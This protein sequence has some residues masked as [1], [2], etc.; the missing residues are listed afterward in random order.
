M[1]LKGKVFIV[2][3]Y[4]CNPTAAQFSIEDTYYAPSN[5]QAK[6]GGPGDAKKQKLI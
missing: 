2:Y 4:L 5:H 6:F 3:T 1:Q